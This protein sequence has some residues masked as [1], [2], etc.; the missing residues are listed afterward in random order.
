[1]TIEV[2][3]FSE[4]LSDDTVRALELLQETPVTC[5]QI[6]LEVVAG[7]DKPNTVRISAM[8]G[9]QKMIP[10]IDSGS[11]HTFVNKFLQRELVVR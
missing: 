8:V 3:E 2:G 5:C 6:S 4:V 11:S 1:L 9:N 7:S 10:M